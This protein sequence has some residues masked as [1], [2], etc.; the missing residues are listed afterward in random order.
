MNALSNFELE[1]YFNEKSL[2]LA[3]ERVL[4]WTDK[5]AKDHFGIKSFRIDFDKNL[6]LL[7]QKLLGGSI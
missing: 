6:K 3:W 4:R 1:K 2:K 7:N 5:T